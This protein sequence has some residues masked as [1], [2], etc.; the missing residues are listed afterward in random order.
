MEIRIQKLHEK[1]ILP[2]YETKGSSGMDI[3]CLEDIILKPGEIMLVRTGLAME[4]PQ[5]YEGQIRSRSGLSLNGVV[6]ANSPGTIDS[7]YR[8]E[9]RVILRN[10]TNEFVALGAGARIAQLIVAPTTNVLWEVT[11]GGLSETLRGEA[12]FGSTG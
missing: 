3:A 7:D 5:G 4:I 8:G 1:A 9:V 6:V 2:K 10:V 12:G 11:D